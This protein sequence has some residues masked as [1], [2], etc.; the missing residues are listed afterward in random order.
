MTASAAAR[1]RATQIGGGLALGVAILATVVLATAVVTL[2]TSQEGRAPEVDGRL[3]VSFPVTPNAV[4]GIV[5]DLDRLTSLAVLTLHPSGVGGSIV[6]VPVNVDTTNGFGPERQPLSRQPFPPDDEVQADQLSAGLEPLLTLTIERTI[7]LGPS[8]LTEVLAPLGEFDVE[9]PQNVVDFDADGPGVVAQEGAASLDAGEMVE[10]FTAISADGESYD[11]HDVD[12][13]LWSSV[14]AAATGS[15]ATAPNIDVPVD[16]FDRPVAPATAAELVD[17]MLAGEVGVRDLRIN[18]AATASAENEDATDFVVADRRDPLLVFGAVSPSLVSKPNESLSFKL[19][20]AFD[21]AQVASLGKDADGA[22]VTKESMT[23]RF[24]GELLFEQANIV[25]VDLTDAPE[26]LPQ[27]TQLYVADAALVEAVRN[28]SPRFFADADVV[29]ADEV[30]DG[31]DVVV[32]LGSDFL[33]ERA[34]LI[35]I[36]RAAAEAEAPVDDGTAD[37][38]L[39]PDTVAADG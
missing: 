16:E 21:D 32:V 3:V 22:V 18:A 23:L 38:E 11:H 25:A 29:V 2:R 1:K 26:S 39:T 27:R 4:V 33:A 9:L 7:V 12:V 31:V 14:A 30:T 8:E 35:E 6:V 20:V 24:I 28:A 10:A 34:D 36:E 17:R 19:V 15:P 37:F 5:D 13:A